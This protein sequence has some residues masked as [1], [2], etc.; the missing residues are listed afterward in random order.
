M[1]RCEM[2]EEL[3]S[4]YV[5]GALDAESTEMVERHIEQCSECAALLRTFQAISGVGDAGVEAPAELTRQIHQHIAS[6]SACAVYE[7]IL[8]LAADNELEQDEA[9]QLQMHLS[10]CPHCSRESAKYAALASAAREIPDLPAPAE[11]RDQ[12]AAATYARRSLLQRIA[13][14]VKPVRWAAAAGA[15]ALVTFAAFS[16][17][18]NTGDV[19][20][21]YVESPMAGVGASADANTATVA[22]APEIEVEQVESEAAVQGAVRAP[23]ENVRRRAAETRRAPVK[24]ANAP[25]LGERAPQANTA[26]ATAFPAETAEDTPPAAPVFDEVA[27]VERGP[28]VLAEVVETP[29]EGPIKVVAARTADEVLDRHAADEA[30]NMKIRQ[31]VT[32][33]KMRALAEI[34]QDSPRAPRVPVKLLAATF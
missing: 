5:D 26:R 24:V 12:I 9:A 14:G 1:T 23:R 30:L 11:L 18:T 19:G 13:E 2:M 6:R 3:I 20:K 7:Q 27:T 29:R 17:L 16:T 22:V 15:A 25:V 32:E 33:R 34:P 31:K 8:P 21:G 4:C 28:V 10:S